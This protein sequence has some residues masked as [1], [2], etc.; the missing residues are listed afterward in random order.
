MCKAFLGC[1]DKYGKKA[2]PAATGR[3]GNTEELGSGT[4]A[5]S[6]TISCK[7]AL[8]LYLLLTFLSIHS[9]PHTFF[10]LKFSALLG[11]FTGKDEG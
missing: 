2:E 7:Q 1:K 6:S 5:W 11:I 4:F 8:S 10:Q 3:A 9:L